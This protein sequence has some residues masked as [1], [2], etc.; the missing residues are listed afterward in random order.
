MAKPWQAPT[1]RLNVKSRP[2]PE[3]VKDLKYCVWSINRFRPDPPGQD[4]RFTAGNLGSGFFVAPRVFL[5]CHHVM[6]SAKNPHQTGDRYQLVQSL[7]PN[8]ATIGPHFI[9][10]VGTDLH[11]FPD[12]DAAILQLDGPDR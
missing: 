11:L 3:V 7:S 5:T 6:N 1:A 9:P 10:V 8:N 4:K 12:R 2:F